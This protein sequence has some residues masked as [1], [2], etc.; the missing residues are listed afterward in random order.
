MLG[1]P[2]A[3]LRPP[4]A[5]LQSGSWRTRAGLEA[6][7]TEQFVQSHQDTLHVAHDGDIGDAVLA[8]FRGIDV[9]VD[10]L[11]V[12][13]EGGQT[14]GYTVVETVSYTHLDVYKRQALL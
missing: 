11:G 1:L 9:H 13:R 6:R 5:A 3:D 7:P 14:P 12:R 10:D 4:G 8:D 2:A